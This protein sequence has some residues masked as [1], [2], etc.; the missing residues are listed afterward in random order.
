MAH[1]LLSPSS[2]DRWFSCPGSINLIETLNIKSTVS[3]SAAEGTVAHRIGE[4]CLS[5]DTYPASFLNQKMTVDGFEITVTQEMLDAVSVYVNYVDHYMSKLDIDDTIDIDEITLNVEMKCNLTSIGIAGL[6][7]GTGDC[8]I[9]NHRDN[10]LTVIDYKHGIRHAVE[11]DCNRQLRQYA[12][13]ALL[14]IDELIIYEDWKIEIVI[15]QP[16]AFHKD[17]PV[18]IEVLSNDDLYKWKDDALIPA[19]LRTKEKNAPLVASESNCRWCPVSTCSAR[20]KKV[21]ASTM[22]DFKDNAPSLLPDLNLMTTEQKIKTLMH[23]K[24]IRSFL[25]AVES[26]VKDEMRD[27]SQAYDDN[28][29]LVNSRAQRKL[30]DAA[31][32]EITPLLDYLKDDEMYIKR[33]KTI[34][35]LESTLKEKNYS[36]AEIKKILSLVTEKKQGS[37]KLV[38]FTDSREPSLLSV[39]KHLTK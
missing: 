20:Y 10:I 6:D 17:G 8:V 29:K 35:E 32:D 26:Q 13:G 38:A 14:A 27:G 1:A 22:I 5:T 36:G 12:L 30:D 19:A 31:F 15:V 7:G 3:K 23:S 16:R 28:Y 25:T 4:L 39:F 24:M 33:T 37:E 34:T 2:S 9:I 21:I 11:V 18:R